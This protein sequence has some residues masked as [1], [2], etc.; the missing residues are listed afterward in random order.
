MVGLLSSN[1]ENI[2]MTFLHSRLVV[3]LLGGGALLAMCV[4]S[5]TGWKHSGLQ[6]AGSIGRNYRIKPIRPQVVTTSISLTTFVAIALTFPLVPSCLATPATD[7]KAALE[8]VISSRDQ[9][10]KVQ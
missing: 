9:L 8:M 5:A 7:G 2:L 10:K 6:N 3:A 4:T 1:E